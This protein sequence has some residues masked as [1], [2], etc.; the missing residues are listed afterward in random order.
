MAK[1]GRMKNIKAQVGRSFFRIWLERQSGKGFPI[2]S[3]S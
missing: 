2:G 1:M 3:F